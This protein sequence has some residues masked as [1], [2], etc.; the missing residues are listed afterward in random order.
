MK[1]ILLLSAAASTMIMAG[2]DIAPVEPIVETE[3][4]IFNNVAFSGELRTRYENVNDSIDDTA[5]AITTRFA[6]AV[7]ADLAGIAGLSTF[8]EIMAV[9]NFGY[10]EYAPEQ[11]GYATIA[12]PANSRVT[13]AYLDYKTGETLFRIGR[14]A[15]NLDDQ[16]FLGSVNWRQM[17][18]TLMGYTVS[19]NSIEDLGLMASYITDRYGIVDAL[20]GGTE[21]VLLHA[22]YQ[23]MSELKLTGYGY[24][25]GSNS[26]T[27]GLMAAGKAGMFNYIAEAATQKDATLEY[28]NM[29]K[30]TV[31]AMYYRV[32]L[33]TNYNGFIFG[34]AYESLGEADGNSHGFTT[35]LATLHKWQG[36]GD[37]FLGYTGGSSAFGLDDLYAK[38]GYSSPTFGKILAFYHDFSAKESLAGTTDAAGSELDLLYTYNFSKNLNFLGKAAFFSG[39]S[40]SVISAAHND[41]EKYWV[42][43][44]YKF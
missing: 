44:D 29:G 11:A 5:N 7:R 26:N 30:P 8:G 12:D 36:F 4:G 9:T 15:L 14:Q 1:K 22:A 24:L 38:I 16:R 13:Q 21:T 43:L 18:Q 28:Q 10:D 3:T 37:V 2:G 31:D 41:V 39:A 32:D 33:S 42:Q 19:N 40:D 35:P 23:A 17:P 27:Y 25:I 20:S 6:L 34:A